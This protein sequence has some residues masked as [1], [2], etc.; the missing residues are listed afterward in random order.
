MTA[1]AAR[2]LPTELPGGGCL[3]FCKRL[4][5]DMATAGGLPG[6]CATPV[7]RRPAKH[8]AR[9]CPTLQ[10]I[11]AAKRQCTPPSAPCG[12]ATS[13]CRGGFIEILPPK[14]LPCKGSCRRQP[15]EGCRTRLCQYPSGFCV[16]S[17]PCGITGPHGAVLTQNR[18]ATPSPPG[19]RERPPYN[20]RH[21]GG[22]TGDK[23]WRWFFGTMQASSPAKHRARSC[24]TLQDIFAAKRQCTPSSAPCGASTSPCRGGFI[25]ILPPKRLPC[26]GSCRRQP[27]EG[28]RTRLCQYPSGFCVPSRPCGITGPHGAVLTQNRNATPSP[29]GGRERPPYNAGQ[30]GSGTGNKIWRWFFGTMQASS[31]AQGRCGLYRLSVLA[32]P[33]Q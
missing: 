4:A 1:P 9:S 2:R 12:A 20:A 28:C 33:S 23:T 27:T 14:R 5:G 8:G 31:P 24:P 21:T 17:R 26:K 15:T 25:E 30:A 18:N 6:R 10:D 11:S 29:P 7:R 3:L 19:G 22:G 32:G 16:P 13:P